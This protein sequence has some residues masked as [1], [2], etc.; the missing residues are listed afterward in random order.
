M[1]RPGIHLRLLI[2]AF[3]L[4]CATAFTLDVVGV[5]ITRQFMVKRF[6]DRISFLAKYLALNSEVGVLIGDRSGLKSLALNLLGEEDV[7]RVTILDNH[8]QELVDLSRTVTGPLSV[9]EAPVEF[10]KTSDENLLFRSN[11]TPFG[12]RHI[13]GVDY[14]GKVRITFSTHG[15]DQLMVEITRQFVWFSTGLAIIAGLV[16]YFISRSIVVDVTRLADTARQVG[17]G[18]MKLRAQPG[19]L[20]ETRELALAFNSMLDSLEWSTKA[21][22]DAYQEMI[23]QKALAEVGKFSTMIAHEV[24]NP[25]GIIK[26]SLD[27]LKKDSAISSGNT[28]VSYMEDEIRRLN[29]LIEDFLTF[30]RPIRPTFR[31]ADVNALLG[32]IVTRFELQKAG[33]PVEI[34][35]RIPSEPYNANVDPDLL[36]R[37]FSNILRNAFEANGDKGVVLITASCSESVWTAKIEDEGEGI[38]PENLH[39]IFEPFFTTRSKG[40]GLGLAYASQVIMSHNGAITA[41][42]RD[43]GGAMFRVEIPVRQ[44]SGIGGRDESEEL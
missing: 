11:R 32:E 36:A 26:S 16:F 38:D 34:R 17:K 22:E 28:M 21:L 20:P 9:V 41:G 1:K 2:A 5:H 43:Q 4:I 10:K 44:G 3:L 35:S 6:R 12:E 37:V 15:I 8:N 23:H 31:E 13:P 18:D 30:A 24:K 40:T 19:I 7:A 25:L 14:I 33:S 27:I 39:K 42:N 29:R